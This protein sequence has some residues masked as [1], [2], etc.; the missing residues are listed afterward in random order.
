[1]QKLVIEAIFDGKN[2]KVEVPY[3]LGTTVKLPDIYPLIRI[4]I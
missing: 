4:F 1:M 3:E 2:E